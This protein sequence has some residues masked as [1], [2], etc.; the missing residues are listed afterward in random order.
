MTKAEPPPQSVTLTVDQALEHAIAHHRQG[1]LHDAEQ[2]YRAVLHAAPSSPRAIE[3]LN[4][5]GALLQHR[6]RLDEAEASYRQALAIKPDFPEAQFNLSNLLR[7]VGRLDEAA[8]GYQRALEIRPRYLE[9]LSNLSNT[10]RDLGR[11][12]DAEAGYRQ[13]L[14]LKPDSTVVLNNL[15]LLLVARG[16]FMAGLAAAK[17]SLRIEETGEAKRVFIACI[18]RLRWTHDDAEIS[19]AMVRALTEPWGRPWDLAPVSAALVKLNPD[20]G[21]A[22]AR[23]ATAWPR[24]LSAQDLFGSNGLA[25]LASHPLLSALL[26]SA[27]ICDIEMERFLTLARRAL[28]DAA[29][30]T[31]ADTEAGVGLSFY[32]A[33]AQ[34]CFINEYVFSHGDEEIQTARELRKALTA[35]L[36]ANARVPV[37]WPVAVA[38]YFP[39]DSL[40]Q[41][42]RLLERPWPDAMTPVL[43]QHIREPAQERQ[44]RAGIPRLTAID[45]EISRQV[46]AQYEENPY[47]RWIKAAPA[48][49]AV[50]ISEFLSRKF[51]LA[52]YERRGGTGPVEILVA[53]CG[54]GQHPIGTAQRFLSARVLAVDLSLASLAYA[55]RKTRELGLTSIEYAQADLLKLG[56]FGRR[57]D[58]IESVGVLHHL[59]DPWTGGR[60]LLSLLRPG[61]FM[62][63]GLYSEIARRNIVKAREFIAARNYGTTPDEIRRCR[64]DMAA[65]YDRQALGPTSELADFFSLSTCRDLLFHV[66]E[67]RMTLTDIEAFL[68][69]NHLTFLGFEMD[70][71]T[72]QAYR[73]RFP[74]DRAATDLVQWQVFEAENPDTFVGMYQFWVQKPG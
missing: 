22:I 45:D 47:P 38:A 63:L 34:Q 58:V 4:N 30:I 13:A 8:A 67:H 70:A 25:A 27:P 21:A 72:L 69:D 10:L 41:A 68:R 51:P 9:A 14:Q 26:I 74:A 60:A 32:A 44:E 12:D 28:L 52:R 11:L 64:Q 15:A 23:A 54:T 56:S 6:G 50:T 42:A 37:L 7:D 31:V 61:G 17:Q 49:T 18:K 19:A 62:K 57:F 39:L 36:D 48:G 59:A 20:I 55:R 35:A 2:L 71:E 65:L 66:Q 5:L 46:Q 3:A 53:G 73:L 16:E 24:P 1:R 40:P 43:A 29:A 33:L